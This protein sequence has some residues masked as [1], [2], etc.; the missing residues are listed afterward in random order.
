M[1]EVLTHPKLPEFLHLPVNYHLKYRFED[2]HNEQKEI[3]DEMV[4]LNGS[5]DKRK[6]PSLKNFV[7]PKK[8]RK[9][10]TTEMVGVELEKH[11]REKEEDEKKKNVKVENTSINFSKVIIGEKIRYI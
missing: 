5:F 4:S 3:V 6:T 2:H 9:A 7:V 8:L 10:E 1:E 11:K